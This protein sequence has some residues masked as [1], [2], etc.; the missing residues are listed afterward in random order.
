MD[1]V[2][3]IA[4]QGTFGTGEQDQDSPR[5][6]LKPYLTGN[7]ETRLVVIGATTTKEYEARLANDA[8]FCRRFQNIELQTFNLDQMKRILL[9][10]SSISQFQKAGFLLGD[11]TEE[12]ERYKQVTSYT[13]DLLDKFAKYQ[14]FPEKGFKF[15][16]YILVNENIENIT[17]DKINTAFSKVYHIP[18]EILTKEI[19][20]NSVFL[21]YD[22][23]IKKEIIGQNEAL[24]SIS[25]KI[26]NFIQG[27]PNNPLTFLEMGST[28]VGK[29]QTAEDTAKMLNLPMI[30]FNMGEFK[31][32]EQVG[33]FVEKLAN[34]LKNNYT[35]VILF[36]EIEKA[37]P[38]VLDAVLSLTDK[39]E[40]GSGKDRVESK[41]QI[42]FMTSNLMEKTLRDCSEVLS[43]D[44][45]SSIPENVLRAL[46]IKETNLRPEFYW[47]DRLNITL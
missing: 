35:G 9:A 46:I 14:S 26:L 34:Y 42:I 3:A 6:L 47:K 11:S 21:Q 29:T 5:N 39:G 31:T 32:K 27:E 16:K 7:G 18:L 24:E 17:Q 44:G 15:L 10:E 45:V 1:E 4:N 20:K 28:G 22:K 43:A 33:Y 36:D 41:S 25:P 30:K 13:C 19:K 37:D 12:K 2:H 8:A 38:E 23:Q 40:I